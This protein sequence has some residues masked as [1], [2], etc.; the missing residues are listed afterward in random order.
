MAQDCITIKGTR[1]GLLILLDA[2][3]D[4]N[5][6]RSNLAAKF[7][8][9]R[10]FFRGASYALVPTSPLDRR[11]TA[12][13]E[14]ICREHG[15]VPGENIALPYRRRPEGSRNLPLTAGALTV[16]AGS[17]QPAGEE[18]STWPAGSG[19]LAATAAAGAL[20]PGTTRMWPPADARATATA[21]S[22]PLL[23]QPS[24][25]LPGQMPV[26]AGTA[27]LPAPG[28]LPVE[29]EV[30]AGLLATDLPTLLDE[31]NLRNG[32]EINY[33]GH[34]MWLGDV[35]QGAIIKAGG[36][37]LIM[38]ILRGKAYAGIR[39]NRSATIVA[40]RLEPEQLGI[41]GVLA[42]SPEQ[43][44]RRDYPEIARLAETSIVINPYLSLKPHRN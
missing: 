34:V 37:I 20:L 19:S 29:P 24:P 41:A 21:A 28:P 23:A 26:A 11:E 5:E 3:R 32:Q 42:R 36:H 39:G 4:F 16:A 22:L 43:K 9:A 8:A 30:A 44:T 1:G 15:L 17:R 31:G 2:S 14:A 40:Y 18:D 25:F 38:G 35:H 33:P 12:E 7:A 27:G 6:I 10:G 13:L